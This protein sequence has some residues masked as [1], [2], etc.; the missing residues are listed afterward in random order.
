MIV[1]YYP[2]SSLARVRKGLSS[3]GLKS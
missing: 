2:H 1:I 3:K